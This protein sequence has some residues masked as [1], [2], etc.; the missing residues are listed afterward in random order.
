MKTEIEWT[1]D[2][3][4]VKGFDKF[5]FE[6]RPPIY[7]QKKRAWEVRMII[8]GFAFCALTDPISRENAIAACH[9]AASKIAGVFEKRHMERL[10]EYMRL[11]TLP[12]P[13]GIGEGEDG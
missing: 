9:V 1:G 8:E 13:P 5:Y 12:E 3:G 2:F 7:G 4:R 10:V 6:I 11:G